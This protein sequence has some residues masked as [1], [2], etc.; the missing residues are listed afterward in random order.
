MEEGGLVWWIMFSHGWPGASPTWGT[1]GTRMHYWKKASRRRQCDAS[2][3]AL[4]GHLGSCHPCGCCSD[5]YHLPN[6]CCRPCT[7]FH[8]NGVPWWLWVM[9]RA[10]KQ[11]WFRNGLRAQQRVWGVELASKFP[12]SQSSWASVG[13]AGQKSPI[14]GGQTFLDQR[15]PGGHLSGLYPICQFSQAWA[16]TAHYVSLLWW[17][18]CW[19]WWWHSCDII[20]L[21]ESFQHVLKWVSEYFW[22]SEDGHGTP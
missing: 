1:H 13:C 6:Q 12:R 4:L 7:P 17:W 20:T 3:N 5:M 9:R 16:G 10:T 22:V 2:G 11:K 21:K 15:A 14:H 8:G 18:W 19:G